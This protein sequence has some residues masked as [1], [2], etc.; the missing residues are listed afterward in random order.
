VRDTAWG[1]PKR[2]SGAFRTAVF[3]ENMGM[4]FGLA[5]VKMVVERHGGAISVS[6]PAGSGAEF[7]ITL[8]SVGE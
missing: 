6:S 4:G 8:Q 2:I 7:T 5:I 1:S 3:N